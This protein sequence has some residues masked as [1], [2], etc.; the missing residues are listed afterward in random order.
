VVARDEVLGAGSVG[1]PVQGV[2]L[3]GATAGGDVTEDPDGVLGADGGVPAVGQFGVVGLR[4]GEA[5]FV[6]DEAVADVQ[7]GGVPGFA[8][9]HRSQVGWLVRPAV[10]SVLVATVV[11]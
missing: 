1:D 5:A 3:A 11:A 4:G 2:G 7:V 6:G 8:A 10:R 9:V